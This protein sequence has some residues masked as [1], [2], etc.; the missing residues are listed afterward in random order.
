M[1]TTSQSCLLQTHKNLSQWQSF[2][3]NQVLY[4]DTFSLL[5]ILALAHLQTH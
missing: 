4:Y 1:V 2:M 5:I 3:G